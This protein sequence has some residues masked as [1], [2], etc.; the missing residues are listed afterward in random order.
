MRPE[1][2]SYPSASAPPPAVVLL[3]LQL[4]TLTMQPHDENLVPAL[5]LVCKDAQSE[6]RSRQLGQIG[7]AVE[8]PASILPG[9]GRQAPRL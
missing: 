8:A 5:M 1:R 3:P 7:A 4:R 2:L 6:E 9:D